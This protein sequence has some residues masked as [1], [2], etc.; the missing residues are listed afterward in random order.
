MCKLELLHVDCSL[1]SPYEGPRVSHVVA[2][3]LCTPHVVLASVVI[4]C[5]FGLGI[6]EIYLPSGKKLFGTCR[7]WYSSH[8]PE[9][10]NNEHE[11]TPIFTGSGNYDV[12][13]L[14]RVIILPITAD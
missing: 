1:S 6:H 9:L 10:C 12:D 5:I 7:V 13:I 11:G 2:L 4:A 3:G 8:L 14:E